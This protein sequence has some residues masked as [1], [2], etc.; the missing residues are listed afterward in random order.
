M[1][2]VAIG[3]IPI[4]DNVPNSVVVIVDDAIILLASV[5]TKLFAVKVADVIFLLA[6]LTNKLFA[7]NVVDVIFPAVIFPLFAIVNLFVY[8]EVAVS[9][10]LNITSLTADIY[11][12]LP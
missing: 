10:V 4:P 8:V 6:S 9:Y 7:V 11:N 2:W 3:T 12:L 1:N 5:I